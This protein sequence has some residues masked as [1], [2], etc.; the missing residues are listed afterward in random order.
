MATTTEDPLGIFLSFKV[1]DLVTSQNVVSLKLDDFVKTALKEFS[2]NRILS[3]PLTKN[4]DTQCLGFVDILDIVSHMIKS[5]SDKT[6]FLDTPL[7]NIIN[8]SNRNL[9]ATVPSDTKVIEV[10]SLFATGIH[11]VAV[12]GEGSIKVL[13]QTD[14]LPFIA[15]TKYC[16]SV[17][18]KTVGELKLIKQWIYF[19][20][21]R[22][23][24]LNGLK[25]LDEHKVS[26]LGVV[27]GSGKLI[28]NLSASDIRHVRPELLTKEICLP[29]KKFMKKHRSKQHW[30]S[31][32]GFCYENTPFAE[33]LHSLMKYKY[34]RLWVVD[35]QFRPIGVITLT[36]V[37]AVLMSSLVIYL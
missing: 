37:C 19:I 25:K 9:F 29:V 2:E 34:H 35:S 22:Q 24:M 4:N 10:L 6:R 32:L 21:S 1:L 18:Y 31:P 27:D 7:E 13:S 23:T 16:E 15:S 26:A 20:S 11:R 12:V 14:L 36:D 5:C 30:N 17:H 28:E 3:I 33:A 8:K